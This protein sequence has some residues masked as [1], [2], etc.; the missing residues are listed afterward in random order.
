MFPDSGSDVA[1]C[2]ELLPRRD[3]VHLELGAKTDPLSC[4][5]QVYTLPQQQEK[6]I[7]HLLKANFVPGS[8]LHLR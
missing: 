2:F 6:K 3:G 8:V 7:R 1:S 4:F 5:C